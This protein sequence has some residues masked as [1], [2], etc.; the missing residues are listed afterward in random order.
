MGTLS[1]YILLAAQYTLSSSVHPEV[2][3]CAGGIVGAQCPSSTPFT[4][5]QTSHSMPADTMRSR[6]CSVATPSH[7]SPIP[8]AA[9]SCIGTRLCNRHRRGFFTHVLLAPFESACACRHCSATVGRHYAT[10]ATCCVR[11]VLCFLHQLRAAKKSVATAPSLSSGM[12]PALAPAQVRPPPR[13]RYCRPFGM[14]ARCCSNSRGAG[15]PPPET[16]PLD[17]SADSSPAHAIAIRRT[18]GRDVAAPDSAAEPRVQP[19]FVAAAETSAGV[20]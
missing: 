12:R 7:S 19:S 15:Q 18:S 5:P 3:A 14:H 2:R 8:E 10:T 11:P 13:D 16:A 6:C 20:S 9:C 17:C 1:N 4:S